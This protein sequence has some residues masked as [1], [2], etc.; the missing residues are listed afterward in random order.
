[1]K[2]KTAANKIPGLPYKKYAA[3]EKGLEKGT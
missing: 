2:P 3:E 1:M